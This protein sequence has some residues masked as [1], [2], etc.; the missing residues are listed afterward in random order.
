MV[1]VLLLSLKLGWFLGGGW[2]A[3]LHDHR[4]LGCHMD[5]GERGEDVLA[6]LVLQEAAWH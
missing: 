5:H 4:R 3:V 2:V 6:G 1:I